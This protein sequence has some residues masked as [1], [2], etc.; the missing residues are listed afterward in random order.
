M[1]ARGKS[2][3]MDGDEADGGMQQQLTGKDGSADNEA[4]APVGEL[5]PRPPRVHGNGFDG[6]RPL[7]N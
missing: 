5:D 7:V 3:P 4:A 6:N 1:D 2:N